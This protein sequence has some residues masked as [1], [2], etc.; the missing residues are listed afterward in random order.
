MTTTA[1]DPATL[2]SEQH[3]DADGFRIRYYEAGDGE[4]ALVLH[5]AGGPS[6]SPALA[7]L[8]Q[9]FK[10][11]PVELPGWGAEANERTQTLD[12]MAETVAALA[13]AIGLERYHVIGTSFG[14]ALALHLAI[15]HPEQLISMVL[16][17]PA[18]FRVGARTP[19]ELVPEQL[20]A[21][22]RAHPEREPVLQPPDPEY[23]ARTWPVVERL[24]ASTPEF[25]EDVAARMT[26]CTVRT[27][28]L[29]GTK[30]GLIPPENA[31]T[32]RRLL[33]NC[34]MEYVYD[35]AHAIQEDRPEAFADV[36]G[37]FLTR[38]M[39]YLIPDQDT[40]INP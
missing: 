39:R 17:G 1:T 5:G 33:P 23:A 38:G 9:R 18:Q 4:P 2:F 32:Y 27:L 40:V 21:A 26:E 11:I 37:D 35:A 14:G 10:V 8:S 31:P 20:V 15:L 29:F 3:V 7:L 28:V 25:D 34:S 22:L 19:A 30:D 12:E 13:A 6:L 16:E 36:V 24:L